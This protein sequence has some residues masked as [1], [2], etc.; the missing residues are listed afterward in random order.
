VLLGYGDDLVRHAG[1]QKNGAA[2][3]GHPALIADSYLLNARS[4]AA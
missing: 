2:L 4:A 1:C 3:R